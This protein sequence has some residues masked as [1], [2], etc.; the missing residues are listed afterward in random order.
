MNNFKSPPAT[1][2][3]AVAR[4]FAAAYHLKFF[5][6]KEQMKAVKQYLL[7]QTKNN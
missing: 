1:K 7:F 2:I 4:Q 5:T 3:Y 6:M